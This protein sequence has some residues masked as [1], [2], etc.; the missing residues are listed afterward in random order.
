[1]SQDDAGAGRAQAPAGAVAPDPAQIAADAAPD[2]V[3]APG[4][5]VARE[6]RSLTGE[7]FSATAAIGGTRGA[8]ESV[9]PGLLFVVVFVLSGQRLGPALVAASA[10]AAV[11]VV[12]RLV[13]RTPVTQ[14]VSGLLGVGI[15]VLWAW[16]TG[17]GQDYFAYGLWTNAAYLV[18]FLVSVLVGWPLVGLVIGLFAPDG[19]LTGGPWSRAVAWRDDRALRRRYVLV[20]WVWAGMFAARLAVQVPLYRSAEVGWLGT[21]KLVMG[22]PLTALV[23]WLSWLLVRRSG[24]R[25]APAGPPPER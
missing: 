25:A 21:A 8:V 6:L 23:L 2:P 17:R 19:P 10:A 12:V 24:V 3:A 13:Q 7:E 4:G 1:M 22:L 9:A 18:G 15:G 16:R 5:A 14:A 20:S 11:A